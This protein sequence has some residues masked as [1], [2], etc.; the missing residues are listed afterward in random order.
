MDAADLDQLLADAGRTKEAVTILEQDG[1]SNSSVLAWHLIDLG[2]VEDAVALLQQR[3]AP[4]TLW[5]DAPADAALTG[6][7]TW[8][9]PG[10]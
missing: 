6:G 7:G 2:R 9:C 3:P 10:W 8:E 1:A 5:T 4:R